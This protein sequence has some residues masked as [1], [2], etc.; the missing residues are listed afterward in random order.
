MARIG[1]FGYGSL[2]NL[3]S[4]AQTIGREPDAV[5]YVLLHGWKRDWGVRCDNLPRGR[6]RVRLMNGE[7]PAHIRALNIQP[8][9][10][11]APVNGIVFSVDEDDLAALDG[12]EVC[13]NRIEVT[14]QIEGEHPFDLI[15]TYSAVPE[16]VIDPLV[17][18]IIP[19]DYVAI[20]EEGFLAIGDHAHQAYQASTASPHPHVTHTEYI[21]A[22]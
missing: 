10:N 8:A 20:V 18:I 12:R 15:Y 2:V 17:P 7:Y 21:V 9:S 13:Y 4:L 11:A 1:L 14:H 16:R 22:T 3:A 19:H 6:G 5:Q